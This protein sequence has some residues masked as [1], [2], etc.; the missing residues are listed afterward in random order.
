MKIHHLTVDD[1]Y[2]SLQSGPSGLTA[3]VAAQRLVEYGTNEV[4]AAPGEPLWLR[5]I[6]GFTHFFAI[7]LW[8]AAALVF[9]SEV[10]Q[11][12][13]GMET[14]GWAIVGVIFING[15]FSFWQEYRAEHALQALLKM[16]PHQVKVMRDGI[17]TLVPARD[18]VPGDV[19][20]LQEGD[21]IPA[22]ARVVESHGLRINN[23]TVT[24]ESLPQSRTAD[25]HMEENFIDSRNVLLA[26]TQVV[27]GN[28]QA[29][30]FATGA[31][32]AF[33]EIARQT[34]AVR[35][36]LSPLQI[37][38]VRLSRLVAVLA[39]SFG[40]VFYLIGRST[41]LS[42]FDNLMFAIGIIAANVP[43]G[44]LPTV[45]L[46]LAMGSQRM[47]RRNAIIRHLPA[48][49][50][51]GSASVICTDKTGTL[52]LNQMT[53]RQLFIGNEMIHPQD[54][55]A[56][57]R[58]AVRHP[59]LF[60][61]ALH[62]H[63]LK[64]TTVDGHPVISGDPMEVALVDLARLVHPGCRWQTKLG[65]VPF[66]TQRKRMST[67]QRCGDGL[68][69]LLKG[70]PEVVP[71]L[72]AMS[73]DERTRLTQIHTGMAAKGLRILALASKSVVNPEITE[74]DENELEF[75]GFIGLEDPPRPEVP[76]AMRACKQAGIKVIMITGDHP[77]TALGIA[78]EVGMVEGMSPRVINGD[79]LRHL[80]NTQL[81]LAL[82]APE[83]LFARVTA[84]Q[85]TRIVAALKRKRHIVAVTG[86]GVNDAPAL[87]KADIGIAMGRN[88][89]DVARAAADIVLLDDNF[90][91]IVAAIEEGRAVF[92][93]IRKF[94]TYILTSNIPE[95]VPYVCF[96]LFKIPLPLTIIQILAVDLGTDMLPAL[97]LGAE[98]PRPDTMQQPLRPRHERL[99]DWKLM[100]RAYLWLGVMQAA[101]AMTA[102]FFVL[103]SGGWSYGQML[104]IKDPLYLQASTACL[105][106]IVVM[107]V[108][109]IFLCRHPSES[110]LRSRFLYNP[111]I[112]VGIATE[113]IL[114]LLIDYTSLG[115]A[116]FGTAPIPS[117]V[118]LLALGLAAGMFIME[119]LR[120]V[121]QRHIK[122]AAA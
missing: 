83:I 28:A 22:D 80:T 33:G 76:A 105:T 26:G 91:S 58:A 89:T 6:K 85:K 5:L 63:D 31:H 45:T 13:Q 30:V 122:R 4:A 96:V 3:E 39:L 86:D 16:L 64:A 7:I 29:L 54:R 37:E 95:L 8:A 42:H 35:E 17:A 55:E 79:E 15:I 99:L 100:L 34:Q 92:A 87:K 2:H 73:A 84:D 74:M 51:L 48:V 46:A 112:F 56:L 52:T 108:A 9:V 20:A 120:K 94:L 25:S 41:G 68:K 110:A 70:A 101:G 38:I 43:E 19:I 75:H 118:W 102:F 12:G 88:G 44:L 61:V 90:A 10:Q 106:T 98:P 27:S 104:A 103:K 32:S 47:A 50:T 71:T 117:S 114:I 72:C 121:V 81:Q 60:D 62:C 66:D 107:Q 119:E 69:L 40:G 97:A 49:E 113:L 93:N 53:A 14:L 59:L 67:V 1:A 77:L 24:G 109:N 78:R 115:N 82:D 65:E 21:S 11:P 23:A 18:L 36:R 57:Q 116:L 111:V